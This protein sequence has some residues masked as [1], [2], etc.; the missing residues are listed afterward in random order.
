[1]KKFRVFKGEFRETV[2]IIKKKKDQ[3]GKGKKMKK[4]RNIKRGTNNAVQ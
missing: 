2:I 3:K 4:K 1:M